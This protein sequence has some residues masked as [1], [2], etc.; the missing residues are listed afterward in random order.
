[1]IAAFESLIVLSLHKAR[2]V[3]VIGNRP[4]LFRSAVIGQCQ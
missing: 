1:M 2:S 3:A 4:C